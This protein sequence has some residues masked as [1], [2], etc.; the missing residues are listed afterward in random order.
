MAVNQLRLG[1]QTHGEWGSC[2]TLRPMNG[3][4]GRRQARFPSCLF[5]FQ[6]DLSLSLIHAS[7]RNW[8]RKSSPPQEAPLPTTHPLI[9]QSLNTHMLSPTEYPALCW[10]HR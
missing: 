10:E 7:G 2:I 6:E 9:H 3:T 1:A 4:D 5:C 8:G